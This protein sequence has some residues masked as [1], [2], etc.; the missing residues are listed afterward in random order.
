MLITYF[1]FMN[2]QTDYPQLLKKAK[3][4]LSECNY[5]L[6]PED[7]I[8][9]VYLRM[10]DKGKE[11]D[12]ALFTVMMRNYFTQEKSII[13]NNHQSSINKEI[14]ELVVCDKCKKEKPQTEYN[15]ILIVK[16]IYT[17]DKTC[18]ECRKPNNRIAVKSYWQKQKDGL[19]DT[20]IK[21]LL[22]NG[23]PNQKYLRSLITKEQIEQKRIELLNKKSPL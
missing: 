8:N 23:K 4:I 18:K 19:T 20:Y 3:S 11:Y 16:G 2:F 1:Y 12:I 7:L 14:F 13:I 5:N 15:K 10:Y 21:S 6:S 9:E 17:K 22:T